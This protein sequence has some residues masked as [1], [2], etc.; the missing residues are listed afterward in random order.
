ME[1]ASDSHIDSFVRT[2]WSMRGE[3]SERGASAIGV[4]VVGN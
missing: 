3:K 1:V 2:I 4:G